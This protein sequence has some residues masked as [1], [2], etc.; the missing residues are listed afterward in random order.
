MGLVGDS[1]EN[2]YRY[3]SG[4]SFSHGFSISELENL[5]P[6]ELELIVEMR[7]EEI[8]RNKQE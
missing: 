4:L 2:H 7:K 3:L 5:M 8:E 6:F 1:L